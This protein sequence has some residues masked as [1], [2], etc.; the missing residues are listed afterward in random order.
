VTRARAAT[1]VPAGVLLVAAALVVLAGFG[2]PARAQTAARGIERGHELYVEQCQSCHL[3]SGDGQ[4]KVGV[5]SLHAVG[6]ASVDFYL[7]TGRMPA[8]SFATQAPRKPVTLSAGDRGALVAYVTDTWPGGP[9]VP[10]GAD[11]S[12]DLPTGGD[13]Y[14]TNCAAC[15]GVAGAGAALAYGAF[16]PSLHRATP[17]QVA[18]AVRVGPANMPV[19]G[20]DQ[21]TDRQL[22]GV[23]SYVEYLHHP[24]DRGGEGL[25]H[26]GPIAEGFVGL[27]FGLA[28]AVAIAAWT[29]HRSEDPE[30]KKP[31]RA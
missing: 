18:E 28:G 6:A 9:P 22:A 11:L 14:R 26:T 13:A 4:S 7:S 10:D 30:P 16:A 24:D 2:P 5:P 21:L 12:G 3:A 27:L 15:H 29:G 17:I 23:V 1:L 19:F 25:G 20:P 31:R 8:A